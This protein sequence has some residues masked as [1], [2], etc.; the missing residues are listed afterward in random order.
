METLFGIPMNR[1]FLGLTGIFSLGTLITAIFAMRNLVMFKMAV[2]NIPRHR[3]QSML[4]VVGLML[5]TLLFSASFATGDT[6]AHSFRLEAL[7]VVGQVDEVVLSESVDNAGRRDF[8]DYAEFEQVR[9]GLVSAPVDGVM[10]AVQFAVTVVA[11]STNLSEPTVQINGLD[12]ALMQG[13]D[14]LEDIDSGRVLDIADLSA[15]QV[16][17]S[18]KVAEEIN[19]AT[20]A[21]INLFFGASPTVMEVKGIYREGGNNSDAASAFMLMGA[22]QD[23]LDQSG[24]INRIFVSNTGDRIEGVEHSDAVMELLE[25]LVEDTLL[26]VNPI[27][28]EFIDLADLIGSA[29]ISIFILFGSFSIIAGILLIALIFVMLAAERK[30][31]LG[32]ARAVGAQREHIVRLFVFEGAVYS[33]VAAAIG[34]ALGVAIGFVMVQIIAGLV[35]TFDVDIV[36]A[37]R[38]RSMAIAYTLGMTVTFLVVLAS[39]WR[40]STLNIVRAVRDLP[41]PPGHQVEVRERFRDVGRAYQRAFSSIVRLRPLSGLRAF[42]FGSFGAWTRFTWSLLRAGYLL[43]IL[44]LFMTL[45]GINA[46]SLAVFM[47]GI[48]MVS[49]GVPLVLM[50]LQ[51]VT[52]RAAFTSAGALVVVVWMLPPSALDAIGLPEFNAGIEMFVLSGV[53]LVVGAVWIVVYNSAYVVSFG[54]FL[55]GRGKMLRPIMRTALAFPLASKFRTG[56]TLAMFSLVVFTLMVMSVVIDAIGAAYE[57]TRGFSGGFDIGVTASPANP[58]DDFVGKIATIDGLDLSL[59]EAIGSQSGLSTRMVQVGIDASEPI[60]AP[61]TSVD[62]EFGST[63]T[64]SFSMKDSR[65]QTDRDVWNA[66]NSEP[67]TVVVASFVVPSKSGFAENFI[68]GEDSFQLTG[69]YRDDT[70]LPETYIDV[71]DRTLQKSTR[72]RVI[73]VLDESAPPELVG[74]FITGTESMAQLQPMPALQFSIRLYDP[75]NAVDVARALEAGFVANGMQA[76]SLSKS[77]NDERALTLAFNRLIRGFMSLGIVVGVAGLGVIA[78]RSV[79]ERRA[80]IGMLRAIGYQRSMVQLSFL[81][82][83]SFIALLGIAIGMTLALGLSV[84]IVGEIAKSIDGVEYRIPWSS[85]LLV[86]SVTYGASLLT[87]FL[88]AKQASDIYPAEA[89]RLGE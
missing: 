45:S 76:Q 46:E 32:I 78:A 28:E 17:L 16:Y 39:A 52:E 12:S 87:T 47:L 71:F 74:L 11:P 62:S 48:S 72:L 65:Y 25:A 13:F 24:R 85:A 89:L 67:G 73:G 64:Y 20:G 19:V 81:I 42:V 83:S 75:A 41:E 82:E 31:E 69:F 36:F 59:I 66:L 30:R 60:G 4:I 61:L 22:L 40:A 5:A 8:F 7:S 27:K 43:V 63:V 88:P 51:V 53:M 33:L 29:F 80:L 2:R 26:D 37:F 86:F 79:V 14:A 57:D 58:V 10:P 34:S 77:V 70:E 15:K 68:G 35:G 9:D 49:I 50:H 54:V 6:I 84:V 3:A 18:Q 56:M 21:S 38:I 1:L 44:G 55:L 23:M